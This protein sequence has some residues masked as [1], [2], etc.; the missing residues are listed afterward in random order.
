VGLIWGVL[1]AIVIAVVA[2]IIS[3][4][5]KDW[6]SWIP[7]HLIRRAVSHLPEAERERLEEEWSS[8]VNDMPGVFAKIYVAYGYLSAA[9]SISK[10]VMSGSSPN[11]AETFQ[12]ATLRTL[13]SLGAA[14]LLV[15]FMPLMVFVALCIK[16]ESRGPVFS[17]IAIIDDGS[18]LQL[19]L[20]RSMYV[21]R[22]Q[23]T[24][25]DD[26]TRVGAVIRTLSLDWLPILLNVLSGDVS[27]ARHPL[28]YLIRIEFYDLFGKLFNK[29]NRNLRLLRRLWFAL[30][31]RFD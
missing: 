17:R 15:F 31:K 28:V 4:D 1:G 11:F 27:L 24:D 14:A 22:V 16:V 10:F 19:T 18:A 8:H 12:K 23:P 2:R 3:E 25:F 21:D 26:V 6:L 9:K 20:F 7:R 13:D 5:V 30:R 29:M